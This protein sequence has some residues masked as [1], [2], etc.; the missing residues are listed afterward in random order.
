MCACTHRA[1]LRL[2]VLFGCSQA[3]KH[4]ADLVVSK[5]IAARVDRPSG[6]IRFGAREEPEDALNAWA[7]N[8]SRLLDLVEK[9]TM[10]IQKEAMTH[11]VEMVSASFGG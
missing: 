4:L 5:A 6:V 2:F 11:K 9:S 10:N 8:I 3:E 7:S 1:F